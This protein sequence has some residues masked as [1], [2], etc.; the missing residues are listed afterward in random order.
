MST[1]QVVVLSYSSGQIRNLLE[2]NAHDREGVTRLRS[3]FSLFRDE[4]M[5]TLRT[6]Y[7]KRSEDEQQI[8]CRLRL[9]NLREAIERI[10]ERVEARH[11]ADA[12]P[13]CI[14]A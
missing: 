4:Y 3:W 14:K 8:H 11:A 13:K 5:E 6:A 10:E 7:P 2:P 1:T 12:I 9:A